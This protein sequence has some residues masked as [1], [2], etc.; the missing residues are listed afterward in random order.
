MAQVS[1]HHSGQRLPRNQ[2]A[3]HC[4][5]KT[6]LPEVRHYHLET[7][8][9]EFLWTAGNVFSLSRR[10]SKAFRKHKRSLNPEDDANAL[11]VDVTEIFL[12]R[13]FIYKSVFVHFVLFV[14]KEFYFI[15]EL[16]FYYILI[17]SFNVNDAIHFPTRKARYIATTEGYNKSVMVSTCC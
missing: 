14:S 3:L 15:G 12:H 1:W 10:H 9:E 4:G 16:A 8:L 2:H 17:T 5:K 13:H 6:S 7:P 11:T